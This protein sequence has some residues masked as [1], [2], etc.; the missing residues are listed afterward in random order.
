MRWFLAAAAGLAIASVATAS[1]AQTIYPLDRAEILSGA[2]F[3]FK[4]EFPGA[5]PQQAVQVTINGQDPAAVLGGAATFIE[6][7]DGNDLSAYWI[8]STAIP[9]SRRRRIVSSTHHAIKI[10]PIAARITPTVHRSCPTPGV[11]AE[12]ESGT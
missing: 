8:R 10:I 12:F 9:G 1:S 2:R 7:E 4:V 6:K 5:P 11:L 3:D